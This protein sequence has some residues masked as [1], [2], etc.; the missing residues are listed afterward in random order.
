M[1]K[2][3]SQ[4]IKTFNLV[5]MVFS[6]GYRILFLLIALS[7]SFVIFEP[8]MN[9]IESLLK[10][11]PEVWGVLAGVISVIFSQVNYDGTETKIEFVPWKMAISTAVLFTV[12]TLLSYYI[13]EVP[14]LDSP[15]LGF[16]L[17]MSIYLIVTLYIFSNDINSI[18]SKYT[19][20]RKIEKLSDYVII[21]FPVYLIPGTLISL[22]LPRYRTLYVEIFFI[23][24]LYGVYY[25]TTLSSIAHIMKGNKILFPTYVWTSIPVIS[26]FYIIAAIL[27]QEKLMLFEV[28]MAII[29]ITTLQSFLFLYNS[30]WNDLEED[31]SMRQLTYDLISLLSKIDENEEIHI[32]II[33]NKSGNRILNIKSIKET[34]DNNR[35]V[36]E[37]ETL[38]EIDRK[39]EV[40]ERKIDDLINN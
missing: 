38:D 12:F 8:I 25:H 1:E 20:T 31:K 2:E 32:I 6:I 34:I 27:L 24:A 4:K 18:I 7:V 19:E 3:L 5:S 11:P 30:N 13:L 23:I 22:Y 16:A 29:T 26:L 35:G 39:I 21:A 33:R 37:K 36:I 17:I 15:T 28:S 14:N 10:I 40:Y 9:P